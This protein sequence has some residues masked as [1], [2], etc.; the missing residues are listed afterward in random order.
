MAFFRNLFLLLIV[1]NAAFLGYDHFKGGDI[2][3][4][5]V[6]N[7]KR[8][9]VPTVQHHVQQTWTSIKSTNPEQLAG[10]VNAAFDQLKGFNSF[11]DVVDHVRAKVSGAVGGSADA[12]GI[13]MEDNVFVLN[14]K[15][16]DKVVDGSRPALVEFYAPWCGHCK[17][18]AP[19]YAELGEAFATVQ[20]RVV[21]AKVN[22]DEQRDLGARFGIQGFPTLKWFP[23]GVTTPDG[24]ED[25]RGGRDLDSL[26]K[27]VHEK[28]GVRPRVKSHKSDV[29]VLDSQNFNSIVK[30]PKTNVL[31]EFYAPWCGHCKN[32]A[33]IY[34]K[35]ATA[36]ANEPNCKVAK[37]D[38]DSERA[39]GTEYEISG[40]PTIKFFAAGEDKEPVAYEGP[41]SE[42]GFIEYLNKQCGT[43]RL[44]GGSLDATAG[45][46]ADLDQLA[47]KF[48]S[49]SDKAARE[50]IQKEATTAAAELGTR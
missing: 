40:F 11:S 48:A 38:A 29:V 41:R 14:D 24:I 34:E 43:H 18:L 50:T 9:D 46:I 39:I 19:T 32:L 25:Y 33:P 37:I 42:A 26:S 6:D 35:V 5:L 45:R 4:S 36:F 7:A 3:I 10:H 20:D 49:T 17:K 23:K 8:L 31:V 22:A 21:I 1:V 13:I 2:A 16:F 47:I 30:D 44:V 12:G 15:N 27:F 28:S